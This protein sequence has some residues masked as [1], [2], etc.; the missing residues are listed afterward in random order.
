LLGLAI[1]AVSTGRSD[2][3][4]ETIEI[5]ETTY[6][7]PEQ[8]CGAKL[9]T[10]ELADPADLVQVP[11]SLT[12][13]DYRIYV[14]AATRDAFV[15]M[16]EAATKDSVELIADSGF[17]SAGFQTRIIK[18]RLDEGDS[19]EK[20]LSMVAPPGYSEHHTGTALDLV[21]SE[22]LFANTD[23]YAWLKKQAAEFGFYETIPEQSERGHSWESWH[24]RFIADSL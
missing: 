10:V 1:V 11:Q 17:R 5:G 4:D 18:R 20:I 16:T 23:A 9:D 15:S 19:I 6:D 21:P 3:C 12:F 8:W 7:V 24:W 14:T 22:A 13:E 2:D